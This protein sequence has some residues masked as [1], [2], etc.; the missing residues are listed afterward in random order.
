MTTL[1]TASQYPTTD[2]ARWEAMR[3]RDRDLDGAFFIAVRTTGVYCLASCAGRP[4]RK[5]VEFH[6]T[7]ES[8]R[9]AGFRACLRCQPDQPRE[10]LRWATAPTSLGLALVARSDAGLRLVTLGDDRAALVRDLERRFRAAR[11]VEDAPGLKADLQAVAAEIDG[12]G[13]ALDLPLDAQGTPLQQAVW[14]ALR[15]IPAGT[16]VS[17][18]EV[19]KAIGRPAAARAVAQACGAN[20]LAVI[21]PCHRVVRADGGLS[22]YRWGV[23]RKAALLAREARVREAA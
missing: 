12:R 15:A 22:G 10:T 9:A 1:G 8:A 5:N 13:A 20:P 21:T 14:A 16:T 7:R 19:A 11:L 23:E 6:D 18:A 4:L 2:D 3:R 17:Y